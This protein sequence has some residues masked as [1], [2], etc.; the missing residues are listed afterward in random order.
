VVPPGSNK[1]DSMTVLILLYVSRLNTDQQTRLIGE[2][3]V[4]ETA[5]NETVANKVTFC[6]CRETKL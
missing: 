3:P 2:S 5:E 4:K 6:P 1:Q